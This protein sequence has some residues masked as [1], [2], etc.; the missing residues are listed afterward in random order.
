MGE[1]RTLAGFLDYG[2]QNYPAANMGLVFW[3]HGGGSISGVCFDDFYDSDSLFL[4]EIDA[5]LFSV[6][7]KMTEPFEFI[8]FDACLMSTVETAA[9]LASHANYM[10]ASEETEPGYGWDYTAIGNFLHENPAASG[11]ELGK[12]ICDSFYDMCRGIGS[13]NEATLSV[14]DL[15]KID[16][17]ML[18]FD[19][20][21]KDI[22]ELTDGSG[23]LSRVVRN[24]TAADN[25]GGNN[26]SSGY[27]SIWA[28]SSRQAH[29]SPATPPRR[30]RRCKK[31]WSTP[32]TAATIRTPAV[33]PAI[34]R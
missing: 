33:F 5:A 2:I 12:V 10:V 16:D 1:S 11:A 24:I 28:A 34:I 31:R 29:S 27:T 6:Y 20:Y 22:Y 7:D 8:G 21:A 15:T 9:I 3:D 32:K 23:E 25:F 26:K 19:A 30:W 14:V 13:E 17:L 4:K 18:A